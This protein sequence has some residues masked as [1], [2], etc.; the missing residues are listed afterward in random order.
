[1]SFWKSSV[2]PPIS[3]WAATLKGIMHMEE[4]IA[5]H[6]LHKYDKFKTLCYVQVN[7]SSSDFL[8]RFA[9]SLEVDGNRGLFF[10]VPFF[11]LL[12]IY[13][14]YHWKGFPVWRGPLH[15]FVTIFSLGSS[16]EPRL[17]L[18][19]GFTSLSITFL[20]YY[21][22]YVFLFTFLPIFLGNIFI[23]LFIWWDMGLFSPAMASI[24]CDSGCILIL[25]TL[26]FLSCLVALPFMYVLGIMCAPHWLLSL[27]VCNCLYH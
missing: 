18:L 26:W 11:P 12:Q 17:L 21:V 14:Q 13:E 24:E 27:I 8:K 15:L 20:P 25:D 7:F 10:P 4:T 6:A 23:K 1:M 19:I 22:I 2:S 5:L 16:H 9:T 3:H